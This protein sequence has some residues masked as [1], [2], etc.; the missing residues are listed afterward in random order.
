MRASR[1]RLPVLS[2][3]VGLFAILFAFGARDIAH[4]AV[5][6]V[7]DEPVRLVLFHGEGC[8]HCDR[9][10]DF[11]EGL[12]ERWPELL[13]EQYEVWNDA[14][15]RDYFRQVTGELGTEPRGVPTIVI[16]D[17][18]WVGYTDA[19]GVEIEAVVAALLAGQA[20][21]ETSGAVVEV[22]FVGDVD[23]GDRSLVLATVIIGFVDGVNPCSLWVLSML[24]A[25]VL[26][27]GS[28]A[29][30]MLVGSIFL[31]ITAALYG[32]YMVGAYS[33]LDYASDLGWIRAAVAV[34]A[35]GF[36]VLHLKEYVTHRGPSV[37]IPDSRKPGLY[38]RMRGLARADRSLPAVIGGTAVLAVGVS[39]VETPCTAGLPLL[40][41]DMLAAR[42]VSAA[43]AVLL[44]AIYLSVFLLD[45][46]AIFGAAVVTLRAA[47]LQERHGR[48]LQLVSGTLMLALALTMLFRPDLL[49]SLSGTVFVFG[50]AAVVAAVVLVTE[51]FRRHPSPHPPGLEP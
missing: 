8:P 7:D 50:G 44:F 35:G 16:A 30:V 25:L 26:H 38:Q 46:L 20:A 27:S 2:V 6:P 19:V 4:A 45:E 39:L 33:V 3:L 24:L 1:G 42:D 17:R 5:E 37:T 11:L 23:V 34:I 31:T 28:R 9:A 15:N 14:G 36:G 41:T 49:E 40:W 32:L 51:R 21:P 18:L 12:Q 10:Q 48:A 47:K 13:I 43:G 29:R 22:P